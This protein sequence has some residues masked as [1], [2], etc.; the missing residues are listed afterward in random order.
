[1]GARDGHTLRE[2]RIVKFSAT[3]KD[4]GRF[5]GPDGLPLFSP[6][7]EDGEIQKGEFAMKGDW[8]YRHPILGEILVPEGFI[9][10]FA[11]TP[12][13]MHAISYFDPLKQAVLASLPHDLLYC[14]QLVPRDFADVVLFDAM[15]HSGSN[16]VIATSYWSG[17][18]VGG[19]LPWLKQKRRNGGIGGVTTRDFVSKLYYDRYLAIVHGEM[20][21]SL[22]Y[23]A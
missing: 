3:G 17:V 9:T 18:R 16:E 19:W 1:M 8:G 6:Y 5:S 2:S 10:D 20:R 7:I 13:W 22:V 4:L 11:S 12:Q 15:V 21:I 14:A 23:A